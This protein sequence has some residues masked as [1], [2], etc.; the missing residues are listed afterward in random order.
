M[1]ITQFTVFYADKT[2]AFNVSSSSY[3][4]FLYILDLIEFMKLK[5]NLL[6]LNKELPIETL[7]ISIGG[8]NKTFEFV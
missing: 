3:K 1:N 7:H 2:C 5:L 6:I 8:R 4:L